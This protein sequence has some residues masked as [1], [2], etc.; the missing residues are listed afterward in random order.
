MRVPGPAVET[1]TGLPVDDRRYVDKRFLRRSMLTAFLDCVL[2]PSPS[3]FFRPCPLHLSSRL[4]VIPGPPIF[5][6]E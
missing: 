2:L 3:M 6:R 4:S 1:F 5:F